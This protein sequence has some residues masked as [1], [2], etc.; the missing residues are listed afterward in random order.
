[1]DVLKE[2]TCVL[3]LQAESVRGMPCFSWKEWLLLQ[4]WLFRREYLANIFLENEQSEPVTCHF[5]ENR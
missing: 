1:M 3:E 5:Q 4:P 2:G